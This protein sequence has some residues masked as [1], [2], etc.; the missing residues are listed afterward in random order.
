MGPGGAADRH[1]PVRQG[2]GGRTR[3]RRH[4]GTAGRPRGMPPFP[5]PAAKSRAAA[6]V[7]TVRVLQK[8]K[9]APAA[10]ATLSSTGQRSAGRPPRSAAPA[11]THPSSP[12]KREPGMI[13]SSVSWLGFEVVTRTPDHPQ[14]KQ[15][16]KHKRFQKE[17]GHTTT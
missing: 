16:I 12:R 2:P 15:K 10:P 8:Q 3:P 5:H 7:W 13:C 11:F 9:F 6:E 4:S 14:Y 17:G 1:V